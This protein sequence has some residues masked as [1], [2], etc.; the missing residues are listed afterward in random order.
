MAGLV[1]GVHIAVAKEQDRSIRR[2][3]LHRIR[4]VLER[5]ARSAELGLQLLNIRAVQNL[6]LLVVVDFEVGVQ[7]DLVMQDV[8]EE[9]LD[10]QVM[11]EELNLGNFLLDPFPVVGNGLGGIVKSEAKRVLGRQL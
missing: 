6:R 4:I 1:D 7:G 3:T 10:A 8:V 5:L 11:D 9:A 2:E